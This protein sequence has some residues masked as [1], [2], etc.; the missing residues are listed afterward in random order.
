MKSPLCL[1][2]RLISLGVLL[3]TTSCTHYAKVS[4]H[5]PK[6]KAVSPTGKMIADAL[7][8]PAETPEAQMGR[9]LDAAAQAHATLQVNPDDAQARKDY[10]FATARLFEVMHERGQGM[11]PWKTPVT[12][13]GAA[14]DW[15]F[16]MTSD[17]KKEH[18]PAYFRIMP[19]D[20]FHFKG[21][22]IIKDRSLKEGIGAPM[23]I[24]NRPEFDPTKYDP[25][26][27]GRNVY[28][29]VTEVL[30]FNGRT[31]TAAY[32]DPLS[33]ENVKMGSHTY[34]VA[35]DF[36][37]PIGL[38]LAELKP[39]KTELQ[40]MF[41]PAEFADTARLARLQPYD[42][43]KTPILVIHGLGDSQATWAPMIES[44]RVDPT[45]RQNYQI[46]FFSYPTGFPFP[47]MAEVLRKKMDAINK[48]YPDR[49]PIVVIGH[50]MGG[51]I[52]RTLITDSG[53]HIWNAYF[54]VPPDKLPVSAES[55]ARLS[56]ALIF[57]HRPE[58]SRVIFMS[59]SLGGADMAT[60]WMGKIGARIIGGAAAM[61]LPD[62]QE[63]TEAVDLSKPDFEGMQLKRFP[64]AID[65]LNPKN[66][67]L[68]IINKLPTTPGVPY[69][70]VIGD[71]GKGGNL[72][73]VYPG[74]PPVSSDGIVPYW[75]SHIDGAESELI[76]PSGHW[77]N[78]NP[79]AIAEVRR[80]LLKHLRN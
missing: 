78:Q 47:L 29:G 63:A 32:V 67:F 15:T 24:A 1:S 49:K 45:I 46:W 39:R 50:S 75:S 2:V 4:E 8:R 58:V 10:N 48:A 22:L 69:H 56:G 23:I 74:T 6:Y 44:L 19:S 61:F 37:A 57:K 70:S 11:Q 53:M 20:R 35:A 59:A 41:K 34:P 54:P 71:R 5:R 18:D 66:R 14:G 30:Q 3:I 26:I 33:T 62:Q 27:M 43:K 7:R 55:R 42:P 64:N 28:Y 12:C 21:K 73:T 72:S 68:T 80:I 31:V 25:F 52:A 9:F 79:E 13:P 40:R 17:G 76:V 60:N 65:A 38:A 16:A 36:T 77:S 51:M